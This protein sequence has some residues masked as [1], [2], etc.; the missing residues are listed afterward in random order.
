MRIVFVIGPTN[1]GK[2]TFVQENFPDAKV[3]DMLNYQQML[4]PYDG[5]DTIEV[6]LER[7]EQAKDALQLAIRNGEDTIVLEHTLLRKERRP[8]YINAVRELTDAPIEC[9]AIVPS[10]NYYYQLSKCLKNTNK[11]AYQYYLANLDIFDIPTEEEFDM[12]SIIRPKFDMRKVIL[13]NR[14]IE[15]ETGKRFRNI[16]EALAELVATG[17]YDYGDYTQTWLAPN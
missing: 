6:A 11:L 10:K 5:K 9:Y 8:M 2:S 4:Y 13:S 17:K 14:D 7:Y 16:R 3:I 15:Y 1:C 12:V